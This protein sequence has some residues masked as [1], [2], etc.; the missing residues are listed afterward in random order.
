VKADSDSKTD[1]LPRIDPETAKQMRDLDE[2]IRRGEG[3]IAAKNLELEE[4]Q[5]E[6][7]QVS[8]S[9]NSYRA[10]IEG[11]PVG[12]KEY[13]ELIADR[14]VARKQYDDLTRRQSSSRMA[15]NLENRR[16][17]EQL[18]LLDPASLP[19]TPSEPKRYVIIA[20][21]SG[22]GFALGLLIA[23]IRELKDTSLKNLK[24]VRAYTQLPILGSVPLL[25]ND[26]VVRRRRRIGWMA[27]STAVLVAVLIMSGSVVY[28][29]AT[30]T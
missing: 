24:D 28:Y 3:Q 13:E 7:A 4:H 14:D 9:I 10:K 23:G 21:G 26:L 27:W 29:Y 8:S 19:R 25:E 15:S 6:L 16:Q 1:A 5:K 17:G 12:Q 2:R 22:I 20:V 11:V 30:R 18:E